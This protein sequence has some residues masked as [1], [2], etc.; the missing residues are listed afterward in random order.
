[1]AVV[2]DFYLQC[3]CIKNIVL[4]H[5][6]AINLKIIIIF[7]YEMVFARFFFYLS[8]LLEDFKW[9]GVQAVDDH[10]SKQ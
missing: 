9:E 8:S 7:I 2:S 10:I 3:E 1:M 5:R 6:D 4:D